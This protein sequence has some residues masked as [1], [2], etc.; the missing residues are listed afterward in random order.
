[1]PYIKK[2]QTKEMVWWWGIEWAREW[3]RRDARV[4]PTASSS[5]IFFF[6]DLPPHQYAAA[7]RPYYYTRVT[8]S[9]IHIKM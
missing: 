5:F 7:V 1:V 6:L 8:A 9:H 4:L 3:T 2:K